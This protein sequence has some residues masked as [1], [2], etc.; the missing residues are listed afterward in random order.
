MNTLRPKFRPLFWCSRQWLDFTAF[1]LH[2]FL[3]VKTLSRYLVEPAGV[4][5]AVPFGRRIYSPLGLPIFLQLQKKT[6]PVTTV[7]FLAMG[8]TT[9]M[10]THLQPWD[11]SESSQNGARDG[12]P[13]TWWMPLDSN[14]QCLSGGRF[15]VSW[16]YQ[17]SYT[18]IYYLRLRFYHI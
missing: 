17:F 18:S 5:P 1:T 10:S 3:C 14:Q 16:G 9:A 4:E 8:Q 15:T 7:S 12:L 13:K 11:S 2:T 6:K